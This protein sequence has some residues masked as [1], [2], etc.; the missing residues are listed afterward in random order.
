MLSQQ[1][2][3]IIPAVQWDLGPL[4]ILLILH[5]PWLQMAPADLWLL[6][7]HQLPEQ[8][9][10]REG[11]IEGNTSEGHQCYEFLCVR[12]NIDN[13]LSVDGVST[14]SSAGLTEW[15]HWPWWTGRTLL[16]HNVSP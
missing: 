11:N 1:K 6:V 10:Q 8:W 7:L 5:L 14:Y 4:G 12:C 9:R 15:T 2:S 3:V 13:T 16:T